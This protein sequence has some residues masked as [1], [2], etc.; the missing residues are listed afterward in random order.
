M[1]RRA[2][3]GRVRLAL[4]VGVDALL[5]QRLDARHVPERRGGVERARPRGVL[6]P[7][8]GA[9][10]LVHRA[11]PLGGHERVHAARL[12]ERVTEAHVHESGQL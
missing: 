2:A 6:R 9:D 4:G 12:R 8:C 1:Q 3:G 10:R 11:L 5:Q 7:R